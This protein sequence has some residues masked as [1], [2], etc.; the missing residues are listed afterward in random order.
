MI[1]NVI[2]IFK[3]FKNV[4]FLSNKLNLS[5][6]IF[7]LQ[8]YNFSK[9]DRVSKDLKERVQWSKTEKAELKKEA[10]TS[11]TSDMPEEENVSKITEKLLCDI[12]GCKYYPKND[13]IKF[14]D[15]SLVAMYDENDKPLGVKSFADAITYA[16]NFGKDVVLRNEKS[17]PPIVKII[18]Y[19]VELAKRLMKKLG[20]QVD[21]KEKKENTKIIDFNIGIADGDFISKKDKCRE[22][23]GAFA[24][25]K[26]VIPCNIDNE[27]QVVKATSILNNLTNEISDIAKIKAGPIK[28]RRKKTKIDSID[29]G[30]EEMKSEEEFRQHKAIMKEA[31][32]V[33]K[34]KSI[35]G[36]KDLEFIDSIYIDYESLLVDPSGIDY[37]KL[38]ENINIEAMIKGITM[39]TPSQVDFDEVYHIYNYIRHKLN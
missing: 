8:K 25:L 37:E 27:E 23:L 34:L 39:T 3:H 21:T 22:L 2:P 7:R 19:K 17:S 6:N 33:A 10:K 36:V 35:D 28:S 1:K 20:R 11:D 18:K 31:Y 5:Y 29:N 26:I 9:A 13:E 32:E 12:I 38:L 24:Y 15:N 30:P 4:H 14:E 16:E